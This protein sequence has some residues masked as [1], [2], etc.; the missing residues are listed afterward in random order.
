LIYATEHVHMP[1]GEQS[2]NL[3]PADIEQAARERERERQEEQAAITEA[4]ADEGALE[5]E[6]TAR[7]QR[8]EAAAER[9]VAQETAA[10]LGETQ[11]GSRN[12]TAAEAETQ[13]QATESLQEQTTPAGPVEAA[14]ETGSEITAD[15]TGAA[16]EGARAVRGAF[17]NLTGGGDTTGDTQA[18]QQ[19]QRDRRR[20][21]VIGQAGAGEATTVA[22]QTEQ[23]RLERRLRETIPGETDARTQT[24]GAGA[25]GGGGVDDLPLN[26]LG[27]PEIQ[28]PQVVVGDR[29]V[30]ADRAAAATAENIEETGAETVGAFQQAPDRVAGLFE[31]ADGR[32]PAEAELFGDPRT[33]IDVAAGA[34]SPGDRRGEEVVEGLAAGGQQVGADLGRAAGGA[35]GTVFDIGATAATDPGELVDV[36]EGPI[37]SGTDRGFQ[38]QAGETT[39]DLGEEGGQA[40]GA[41][42][43]G[44]AGGLAGGLPLIADEALETG[45]ATATEAPDAPEE[46][47]QVVE[48]VFLRG[49]RTVEGVGQ[50]P[51]LEFREER[52]QERT[53]EELNV[54]GLTERTESFLA[55]A[56]ATATASEA[57]PLIAA[58]PDA[59]PTA[60]IGSITGGAALLAGSA[61]ASRGLSPV[62]S[63]RTRFAADTDADAGG[64]VDVT[65]T[66]VTT[67]PVA[68]RIGIEARGR[69]LFGTVRTPEDTRRGIGAPALREGEVDLERTG[70]RGSRAFEP[71]TAAETDIVRA[72]AGEIGGTAAERFRAAERLVGEALGE[73]PRGEVERPVGDVVAETREVPE[74]AAGDVTE[75]LADVEGTVFGSVAVRAQA[76]DF[77]RQPG[78]IDVVVDDPDAARARFAEALEGTGR[79][80]GEVFDIKETAEAPGRR[81]GGEVVKQGRRSL[82]PFETEE[83]ISLNPFEEETARK[84]GASALLRGPGAETGDFDIGPEAGGVLRETRVKDVR[85]AASLAEQLFGGS[86]TER[87]FRSAFADVE[88]VDEPAPRQTRVFGEGGAFGRTLGG[89]EADRGQVTFGGGRRAGAPDRRQ[90]IGGRDTDRDAPAPRDRDQRE[91]SPTAGGRG[92]DTGV[93]VFGGVSPGTTSPG[94]DRDGTGDPFAAPTSGP[95]PPEQPPGPDSPAPVGTGGGLPPASPPGG[96]GG[97]FGSGSFLPPASPPDSPGGGI[98]GGGGLPPASPPDGGGGGFGSGGGIPGLTPTDSDSRR[99]RERGLGGDIRDGEDDEAEPILP[100]GQTFTNPVA[101][102]FEFLFGGGFGGSGGR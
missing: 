26:T 14:G 79:G 29:T 24:A 59:S 82:S 35:A 96:D 92:G 77:R 99:R 90:T 84:G 25:D 89:P 13:T 31:P 44:G 9:E 88:G 61:G 40:F 102:G 8:F 81:R 34:L 51:G 39:T 48:N 94:G 62:R 4:F 18:A 50:A 55:T 65:Q 20:E 46:A 57:G 83:G 43:G 27:G 15:V 63:T 28:D 12:T 45:Q 85:D 42:V 100:A 17:E 33:A 93:P 52:V 91:P 2:I 76:P 101:T 6:P 75:A 60:A 71:T 87:G 3:T 21:T 5:S 95:S 41:V 37:R 98:G 58:D 72:T 64:A 78:D 7:E 67:P 73:R 80:V 23:R 53:G 10:K 97:G 70:F 19:R 66:R 11:Q 38:I 54:P 86:R 22:Q 74:G 49:G 30:D 56:G 16:G 69:S 47:P 32:A 1:D 36:R 68:E